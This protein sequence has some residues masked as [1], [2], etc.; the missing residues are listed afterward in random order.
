MKSRIG[1]TLDSKGRVSHY[2]E[3]PKSWKI[4]PIASVFDWHT[5]EEYGV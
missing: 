1:I 3:I 5:E 2:L 4:E